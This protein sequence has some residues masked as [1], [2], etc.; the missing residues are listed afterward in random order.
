MNSTMIVN[1][2]DPHGYS[3]LPYEGPEAGYRVD[4]LERIQ[5]RLDLCLERHSQVLAVMM[6][7]R[8][9]QS[10]TIEQ[11][12]NCFQYFIEEY[13]RIL[14]AH[15]YDPHYV[16]VAE[17]DEAPSQHY[18]L[19]LLLNGNRIRSFQMPPTEASAVWGRALN[20]FY[21]YGGFVDGLIHVG[22]V[23]QYEHPRRSYLILR[24]DFDMQD[25]MME[26][27]SYFAK[28]HSKVCFANKA[29]VFGASLMKRE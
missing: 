8:F 24:N 14:N 27:F 12:N 21:G 28:M 4:I 19:L 22:K 16:W 3:L 23:M 7:I 2:N 29:R 1:S 15:G 17:R 25:A 6:V 18:H 26:H 9:P 10:L 20:R 11:N 5:E 13:R